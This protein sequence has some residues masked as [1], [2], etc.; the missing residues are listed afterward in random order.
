[1]LLIIPITE[2]LWKVPNGEDIVFRSKTF[3]DVKRLLMDYA[4]KNKYAAQW[5]NLTPETINRL[6]AVYEN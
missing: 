1:M 3:A 6:F 4:E 2:Y 5:Y